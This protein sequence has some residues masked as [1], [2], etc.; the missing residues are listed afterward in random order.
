MDNILNSINQG[1][2]SFI[3]ILTP[4][5]QYIVY[6]KYILL[7]VSLILIF[8]M[9]YS[10]PYEDIYT[11]LR[12]SGNKGIDALRSSMASS[13]FNLFNYDKISTY[14]LSHGVTY[15][16]DGKVDAVKYI[17]IKLGVSIF[18]AVIFM[19]IHILM[20]IPGIVVGFLLPDVFVNESDKSDNSNMAMDIKNIYDSLRIQTKAGVYL[21]ESLSE[22]YLIVKNARLKKALLEL[23]SAIVAQSDIVMAVEEF[24]SKFNNRYIDEF[25]IIMKQSLESGRTVKLL[26]DISA[27]LADMQAAI[28]IKEK[29]KLQRKIMYGQILL[30]GG[31][32]ALC[33]VAVV[34][35]LTGSLSEF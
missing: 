8:F 12:N 2:S 28:N 34:R 14:I 1:W 29:E 6:G 16:S 26:D 22:C 21:T 30:Y 23:T 7:I 19:Q 18:I 32:L 17:M 5:H 33:V 3:D 4:Y 35:Q 13:S 31:V 11:S 25:C 27:Q 24:N 9:V 10:I 15:M 20:A